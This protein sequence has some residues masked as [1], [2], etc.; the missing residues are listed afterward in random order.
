MRATLPSNHLLFWQSQF[1]TSFSFFN[2]FTAMGLLPKPIHGNR[3]YVAPSPSEVQGHSP[4]CGV[5]VVKQIMAP[6]PPTIVLVGWRHSEVASGWLSAGVVRFQPK[7]NPCRCCRTLGLPPGVSTTVWE[8]HWACRSRTV[9]G[10]PTTRTCG[11]RSVDQ[12]R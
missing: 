9:A 10:L 12:E 1:L 2:I 11:N 6:Y 5:N 3:L 7:I 4:D 8:P